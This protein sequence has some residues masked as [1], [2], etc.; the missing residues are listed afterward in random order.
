MCC[1]VCG[2]VGF[3]LGVCVVGGG[4]DGQ[5]EGRGARGLGLRLHSVVMPLVS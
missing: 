4:V 1:Q 3:V 2:C 5:A